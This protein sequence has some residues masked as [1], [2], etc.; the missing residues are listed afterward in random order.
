MAIAS[1]CEEMH[2]I[3]LLA[4]RNNWKKCFHKTNKRKKFF[5][6]D[7]SHRNFKIAPVFL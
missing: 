2:I 5:M 7:T 1:Y 3:L 4:K 6:A